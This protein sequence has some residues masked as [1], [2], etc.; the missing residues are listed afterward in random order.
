MQY[1]N[2]FLIALPLVYYPDSGQVVILVVRYIC[3]ICGNVYDP[4][5]GELH[6][7]IP[8]E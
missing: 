4:E 3:S 8:R 7:N 2:H 1:R 6:P 5:K